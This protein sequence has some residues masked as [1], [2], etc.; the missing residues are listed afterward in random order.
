MILSLSSLCVVIMTTKTLLLLVLTA[1]Q[2]VFGKSLM[3]HIVNN[4]IQVKKLPA[5]NWSPDNRLFNSLNQESINYYLKL[6]AH[7]G[8]S[9]D[10]VCGDT[11]QANTHSII[12]KVSSKHEFDNCLVNP[13]H[14]DTVPILKCGGGGS[15]INQEEENNRQNHTQQQHD[16]S[17]RS[18]VKFTIY[19]VKFSPVPNALEFEEDKEYY[20]LSTSSGSRDGLNYMSG[21]LCSNFN[22]RFSIKIESNSVTP[23]ANLQQN[24]SQFHQSAIFSSISSMNDY[25]STR[26]TPSYG[27]EKSHIRLSKNGGSEFDGNTIRREDNDNDDDE[28]RGAGDERAKERLSNYQPQVSSKLNL[29]S[30]SSSRVYFSGG[31]KTTI[32]VVV[33]LLFFSKLYFF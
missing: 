25:E 12:Y 13:Q 11:P 30:S 22:M 17:T 8:D 14:V 24:P 10:L 2:S 5:L 20:F 9:I 27:K 15:G 23:V 6:N 3:S 16:H 31:G 33:Y 21:G 4:H 29:A 1:P 26:L 28:E 19:F 18:K 32:F 7:I